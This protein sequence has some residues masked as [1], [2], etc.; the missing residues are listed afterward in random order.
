MKEKMEEMEVK[1]KALREEER[2]W[3]EKIEVEYREQLASVRQE[4]DA[5][6]QKLTEQ[7]ASKHS[8]LK[9]FLEQTA[10][11][12]PRMPELNGWGI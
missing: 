12:Q 9:K 11:S 2:T 1:I 8:R 3:M 10:G 5:K 6:E 4:A 7:W